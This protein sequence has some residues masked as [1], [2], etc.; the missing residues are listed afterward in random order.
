VA[1]LSGDGAGGFAAP[2]YV[3]VGLGPGGITIGDFQGR[4]AI[5]LAVAN[6][7]A[8]SA[9]ILY[10]DG[11]GGF[12][13]VVTFPVVPRPSFL[14][15]GDVNKDRRPDLLVG[16]DYSDT[17]TIL[18]GEGDALG[19]PR[20]D[21]L[22][23]SGRAALAEDFDHDGFVDLAIPN[24]VGKAIDILPGVRGGGFGDRL[25]VPLG[26]QPRSVAAGDLNGDGRADLVVL[27][28]DPPALTILLNTT[29][30]AVR[31]AGLTLGEASH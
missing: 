1:I 30:L 10:N 16:N 8:D 17:V 15:V 22:A 13:N 14:L 25:T 31:P 21:K 29:E 11:H 7:L 3:N 28:R 19:H 20:T 24:E 23:S 4:G 27:H 2:R 9:S 5:D 26:H 18:N 12:A 6:S